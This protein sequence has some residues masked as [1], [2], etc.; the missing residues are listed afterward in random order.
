MTLPT[1]PEVC[2]HERK[3][4]VFIGADYK[5]LDHD[6]AREF[7]RQVQSKFAELHRQVKRDKRKA[8]KA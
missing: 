6:Q 8:R 1:K 5:L 3:L 2:V 4:C 7:A